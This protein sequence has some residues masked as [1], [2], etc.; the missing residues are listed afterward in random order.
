MGEGSGRH[1]AARRGHSGL[2]AARRG[3]KGQLPPSHTCTCVCVC[4]CVYTPMPCLLPPT[5]P[6]VLIA[7]GRLIVHLSNCLQPGSCWA[8]SLFPSLQPPIALRV[9]EMLSAEM[10]TPHAAAGEGPSV[11][12]TQHQAV[13][14][15]V[16]LL[17]PESEAAP[18]CML[19]A[20]VLLSG[21]GPQPL[22]PV[23]L[24]GFFIQDPAGCHPH[25]KEPQGW[26]S[27][28]AMVPFSGSRGIQGG[29]KKAQQKTNPLP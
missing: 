4:A 19:A 12:R 5:R 10:P 13:P 29:K 11:G 3:V 21:T 6:C 14:G 18:A 25:T 26:G 8:G 20:G 16:P 7:T 15:P 23:F 28:A 1:A 9:P 22:P 17:P 2:R 27:A 24:C